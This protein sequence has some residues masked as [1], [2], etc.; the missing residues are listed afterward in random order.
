MVRHT[1]GTSPCRRAGTRA[2]AARR[3]QPR[4]HRSARRRRRE[5]AC[6]ARRR[7]GRARER[8][9]PVAYL[10]VCGGLDT[11][12]MLGGHGTLLCAGLGWL[13]RTG[14]VLGV[15]TGAMHRASAVF[16]FVEP[17]AIRVL[18]QA[19]PRVADERADRGAHQHVGRVVLVG[20]DAQVAG[21]GGEREP[22][23]PD[24]RRER[25]VAIARDRAGRD[26][27]RER[28]RRVSRPERDVVLLGRHHRPGWREV[29]E[30]TLPAGGPAPTSTRSI[31]TRS[32]VTTASVPTAIASARASRAPRSRARRARRVHAPARAR[33]DRGFGRRPADRARSR[34]PDDGGYPV[35]G[36]A[37][38]DVGS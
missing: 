12:V 11:P 10:A 30:R 20:G 2:R 38:E 22:G 5:R 37:S 17:A 29:H 36:V 8:T 31:R 6:V 7:R 15:A 14:D 35:I 26:G 21:R 33:R 4:G 13:V 1:S 28:Q 27:E 25:V 34:A 16:A 23:H 32:R 18:H 3:G 24:H 9:A 19:R